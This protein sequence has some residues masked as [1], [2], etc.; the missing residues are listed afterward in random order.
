MSRK[1]KL[2]AIYFKKV[3]D[4][5]YDWLP[6]WAQFEKI[7]EDTNIDLSDMIVYLSQATVPRNRTQY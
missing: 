3:S 2:L 4:E 6:F 5:I 7:H 1:F